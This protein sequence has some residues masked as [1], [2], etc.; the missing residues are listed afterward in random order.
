MQRNLAAAGLSLRP[1]DHRG[2]AGFLLTFQNKSVCALTLFYIPFTCSAAEIPIRNDRVWNFIIASEAIYIL[3]LTSR[4]Q[5]NSKA[6]QHV[7]RKFAE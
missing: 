2:S 5:F 3:F 4:F 7:Q 1:Q 6:K